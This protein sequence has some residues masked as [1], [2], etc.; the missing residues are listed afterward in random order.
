MQ[1]YIDIVKHAVTL[2]N[3][4]ITLYTPEHIT[5]YN[6]DASIITLIFL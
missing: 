2:Y 5:L 6:N 3:I 1:L 4:M